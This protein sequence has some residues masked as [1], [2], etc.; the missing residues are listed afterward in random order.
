MT[1]RTLLSTASLALLLGGTAVLAQTPIALGH[2]ADYS[3]ATSDVGTPFGQG[4]ADTYAWINKN[5]GINGAKVNI[6]TVDYGYQVPRAIAQYKKWSGAD[7]VAAILGWGTADTEA[8]T[9]FL[10]EDKIPDIS[11]SYAAALSD[12][13]GAG[14][15]EAIIDLTHQRD[16]VGCGDHVDRQ[17]AFA[18]EELD[19]LRGN[20][21]CRIH[22]DLRLRREAG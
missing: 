17:V 7:K 13:T 3:G 15:K 5:G 11:G 16:F 12:P 22:A 20:L 21:D 1:M 19:L 14:G 18:G 4:I 10:A 6:D 2:L 8:L 9:G